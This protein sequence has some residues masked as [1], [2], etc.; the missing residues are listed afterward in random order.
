MIDVLKNK[1]SE[2]TT[3][4]N[5]ED[6]DGVFPIT[7]SDHSINL[8]ARGGGEQF[9]LFV[10]TSAEDLPINISKPNPSTYPNNQISKSESGHVIEVNDT[11]EGQRILIMHN[12]G[13]GIELRADGSVLVS[14]I[15]QKVELIGAEHHVVVENDGTMIYKGNLDLK[16]AGD[17]NID[18]LN[19]NL[20]VRGN[21]TE[22]ITGSSRTDIGESKGENI[23]GSMSTIVGEQVTDTFLGGHSHNIKG[24]HSMNIEGAANYFSSDVMHM[25]SDTR[26][27]ISTP[28]MNLFAT[29]LAVTGE[30]GVIG[31]TGISFSGNG[32]VFE[33]GITAPTFHGD[34]DGNAANTYAQS[35][36]ST[37]TSG[38]GS[39]TNTATPA[40]TKPTGSIISNYLENSVYAIKK[41]K[42]DVG[43]F[44][45]NFM[46][47]SVDYGGVSKT[48]IDVNKARSKL[49]DPANRNNTQLVGQLVKE[50]VI[51]PL[52]NSPTPIKIGRMV[53]SDPTPQISF[54]NDVT[55]PA[56]VYVPTSI[57]AKIYPGDKFNPYK[58]KDITSKTLIGPGISI[59]K[60]LGSDDPTNLNFIRDIS[61]K[62]EIAKYLGIHALIIKNINTNNNKFKNVSVKISESI[63]RP[64]PE[65]TITPNSINDLKLKGRAVVYDIVGNTGKSNLNSLFELAVWWKDIINYEKLI[66]DYDT[67]EGNLKGRLIVILPEIDDN[68]EA[69][70]NRDIET[71]FNGNVFSSGEFVEILEVEPKEDDLLGDPDYE[72]PLV[73]NNG[74]VKF[75]NPNSA[76]LPRQNIIDALEAA[77]TTL[78]EGYSLVVTYNGGRSAR[79]AGTQNHPLGHAADFYI[80]FKGK[81][82]YPNYNREIYDNLINTL[83]RNA[84]DKG[85]RPGIGGYESF[86]HYDESPWRQG[87]PGRA[88]VWRSGFNVKI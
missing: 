25:T 84:N 20:N 60:F 49:R 13:G 56:A 65:E 26:M 8:E 58:M 45:K 67:I 34:L 82:L 12:N 55:N 10:P 52:W 18:C 16:V 33:S 43:N 4:G 2:N 44:I 87:K 64:G 62:K 15:E 30:Q 88:G 46:N 72:T 6:K 22:T 29:S 48:K 5:H 23:S 74:K 47:R 28:D 68:Y 77:I 17:L 9:K 63:Y 37:A 73:P 32:A 83:V 41:V 51:D 66:L 57:Q 38:G 69:E 70:F 76:N 19:Y 31:S 85:V 36:A 27:A 86:I 3:P 59:G 11:A 54:G 24:T 78:G 81:R 7:G 79:D 50:G 1:P 80:D 21:K 14:A 71:H 40:I 39:I 75:L 61:V 35:Y 42:I 53:K